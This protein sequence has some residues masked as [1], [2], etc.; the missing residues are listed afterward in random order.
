MADL[1]VVLLPLT[2]DYGVVAFIVDSVMYCV[3]KKHNIHSYKQRGPGLGIFMYFT[4]RFSRYLEEES[5]IGN[6]IGIQGGKESGI[7]RKQGIWNA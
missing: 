6:G 7:H 2:T 1:K 3:L 5:G 4:N